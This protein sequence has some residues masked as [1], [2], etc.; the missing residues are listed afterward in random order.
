M[1][2][3]SLARICNWLVL[4]DSMESDHSPIIITVDESVSVEESFSPRWLYRRA[5]W[6]AFRDECRQ[7]LTPDLITTDVE[8]SHSSLV[9]TLQEI[10]N[11]HIPTTTPL[12]QTTEMCPTEIR[13]ARGMSAAKR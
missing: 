13:N 5:N 9:L 1:A 12:E 2:S 7:K 10:T 6:L 8:A 11:K 3:P 4:E